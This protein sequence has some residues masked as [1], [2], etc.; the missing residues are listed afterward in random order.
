MFNPNEHAFCYTYMLKCKQ[1]LAFK[2][3]LA[4]EKQHILFRGLKQ[5]QSLFFAVLAFMIIF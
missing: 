3:L 1:L 4:G 5:K 2:H